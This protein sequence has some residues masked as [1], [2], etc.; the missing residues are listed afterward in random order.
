MSTE[1]LV[2]ILLFDKD[3]NTVLVNNKFLE[4]K[5]EPTDYPMVEPTI[6]KAAK[7][8]ARRV[9][10][11]LLDVNSLDESRLTY[12]TLSEEDK[13]KYVDIVC[14]RLLDIEKA[15]IQKKSTPAYLVGFYHINN[16]P[17]GLIGIDGGI[18][19]YITRYFDVIRS[20][21]YL[22]DPYY[23]Y[24]SSIIV[25][26]PLYTVPMFNPPRIY[27]ERINKPLYKSSSKPSR[28][29]SSRSSS[30]SSSR[31]SRKSS[32]R[33]SR[34]SSS[35][36]SRKSSSR[37]SRKSS[38]KSSSKK[39]SKKKKEKEKKLKEKYIKY[40]TKYLELKRLIDN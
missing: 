7:E 40:K 37:S 10:K 11:K 34:K 1:K 33:S 3:S 13:K 15:Y 31:S 28:K 38:S 2:K 17:T 18:A 21:V 36:S 4:S 23:V 27:Y 14:Y 22:N 12:Q 8:A 20:Y 39:K 9:L 5:I 26:K 25:Y 6:E 30:K 16:L 35:R 19:Y 29:S 32:S 24:P